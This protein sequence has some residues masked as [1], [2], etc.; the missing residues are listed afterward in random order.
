MKN[1]LALILLVSVNSLFAQ[2]FS[3]LNGIEDDQGNTILL[4]SF[5]IDVNG[6]YSPVFKFNTVTSQETKIMD[7]YS[8]QIDTFNYMGKSV[9]DYEFFNNDTSNFI[10]V[11]MTLDMDPLGYAARNDTI[12]FTDFFL[13]TVDISKQNPNNVF[14]SNFNNVYRS[15]DGGYT[16]PEDSTIEFRLVSV[17]DYDDNVFFGVDNDGNLIKSLD[18][19]MTYIIVD[20]SD[21]TTSLPFLK[22]YYDVDN[23]LIYRL[24]LSHGKITLNVST[25]NG[26]A[27]SWNKIYESETPFFVSIDTTQ[28]GLLFIA[29]GKNILKSTNS[30]LSF[31]LYKTLPYKLVGIYKKPG[32]EIIFAATKYNLY[33]IEN[34][35][36]TTIKSV[37]IPS[38]VFDYY[39]LNIGNK[40]VFNY[41]NIDYWPFPTYSSDI[42][43]RQ[44]VDFITKENNKKYYKIEQKFAS[45]DFILNYYERIDSGTGKILRYEESSPDSEIVIDD[46]LGEV[47]DSLMV[48]R[49]EPYYIS[50]PTTFE[51]VE[52]YSEFGLNSTKRIYKYPGLLS[53]DYSLVKS[54][55]LEHILLGYDFG[56]SIYDLKGFIVNGIVYGDTTVTDIYNDADNLPAN[57]ELSQNYPN[58]FNPT[59]KISWQSP[60]A[61]FHTLKVYDV[62]GNEVATLVNEFRNAGSYEIDFDASKL[63]SGVYFY[64][65]KAGNFLQSKKMIYLK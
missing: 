11:G 49:F 15:F 41:T 46:L 45:D 65:L 5:G 25:D 6:Q 52:A 44:V 1:L 17:A 26:N 58:P 51:N 4:Y 55:G 2:Q 33:K 38:Y 34:D 47:G 30:G 39:P 40:W 53:A 64:Q 60:V 43:S 20:T 42:F 28:N 59:T 35:S 19:G 57:F 56:T 13:V 61:G 32:S 36:I 62:L 14:I 10:N 22:F 48:N 8:I 31:S 7:A 12:L 50:I 27:Y 37:P 24:N 3:N 54:V 29:D 16:Y 21:V 63:S 23:N 18:N 9:S